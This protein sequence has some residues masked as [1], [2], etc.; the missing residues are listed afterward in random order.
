M[1]DRIKFLFTKFYNRESID[2]HRD[3]SFP[4]LSKYIDRVSAM[5]ISMYYFGGQVEELFAS[6]NFAAKLAVDIWK[7]GILWH[8]N[9]VKFPLAKKASKKLI[10]ECA[11]KIQNYELYL[12][13]RADGSCYVAT[14]V[15]GSYDCPQVWTL[16]RY[17]DN[18]MATTWDGRAFVRLYYLI[19]PI[20][21][22]VFGRLAWF[23]CILKKTL[24]SI[25]KRL[26]YKGVPDTPYC[27]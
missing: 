24:D 20:V 8:I 27:D 23:N 6:S 19:S 7:T 4:E 11:S 15:Y 21:L 1:A 10:A 9:I 5:C 25:V 22:R 2:I 3:D 14:A 26:N 13:P 17:R 18:S 12:V 16:R